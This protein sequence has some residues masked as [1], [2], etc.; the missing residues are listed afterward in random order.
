MRSELRLQ[1]K[2]WAEH[3]IA[4]VTG[5][6]TGELQEPDPARPSVVLRRAGRRSLWELAKENGSSVDAI[7]S[8][9]RLQGEPEPQQ[10]LLIPVL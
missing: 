8:A 5:L 7:R 2:S 6:N 9:N 1:E 10:M 4:M 3:R